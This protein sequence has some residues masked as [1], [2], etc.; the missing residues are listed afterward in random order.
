M[1]ITPHPE[2]MKGLFQFFANTVD[3]IVDRIETQ[4]GDVEPQGIEN[5]GVTLA[6]RISDAAGTQTLI[7]L[8]AS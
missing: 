7:K 1:A 5:Y 4:R 3:E 6:V 2:I 8:P